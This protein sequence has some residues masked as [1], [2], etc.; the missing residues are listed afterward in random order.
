MIAPDYLYYLTPAADYLKQTKAEIRYPKSV[1][2]YASADPEEAA[3]DF[4]FP[5]IVKISASRQGKGVFKIKSLDELKRLFSKHKDETPA[6]VLREFIPNDGDVRVF[7][8]G[9]QAIGAMKRTPK[10]G[11]FRSNI[12]Q[13]GSGSQFDLAKHL[14]VKK[15]AEKLSQLTRTEI[16]GVDI[17]LHQKTQKPYVLEINPGPQFTG[18]EKYTNTNAALEII[19]FF[20]KRVSETSKKA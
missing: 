2:L 3:K 12:S 4:S 19:K 20:E 10:K 17:M 16:A 8:V 18:L 1:V 11:D 13:G 14:G 7:T 9:Y 6:L 5:L 15:M